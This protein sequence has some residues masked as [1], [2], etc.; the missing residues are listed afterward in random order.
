[1][2][3]RRLQALGPRDPRRLSPDLRL[4]TTTASPSGSIRRSGKS[5]NGLEG[6]EPCRVLLSGVPVKFLA[7]ESD[8]AAAKE[9]CL[10]RTEVHFPDGGNRAVGGQYGERGATR[11]HPGRASRYS[12]ETPRRDCPLA[13]PPK[14]PS[15]SCASSPP[16]LRRR[17]GFWSGVRH[18]A[19]RRADKRAGPHQ[20]PALCGES[21]SDQVPS[22][23]HHQHGTGGVRG[24][25][26]A[27][28]RLGDVLGR[29]DPAQRGV[30][31]DPL[32]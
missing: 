4:A 32:P 18:V 12:P 23:V 27:E 9:M 6:E 5:D 16:G 15:V 13:L 26:E 3:S 28:D 31:G 19:G 2:T 14:L 25:R 17:A 8:L 29:T 22:A 11:R 24:V 20:G 21:A 7:A 10:F 1:M 30:G